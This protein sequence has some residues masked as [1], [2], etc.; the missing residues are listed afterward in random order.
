MKN[1]DDKL[2]QLVSE[3]SEKQDQFQRSLEEAQEVFEEHM[4]NKDKE[5]E[6]YGQ[7]LK[8]IQII[9]RNLVEKLNI[10]GIIVILIFY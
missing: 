7:E 2:R 10:V 6:S 8:R 4:A 3:L 9:N 5:N 1:S